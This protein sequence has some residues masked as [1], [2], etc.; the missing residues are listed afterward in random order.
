VAWTQVDDGTGSPALYRLKYAEP[1]IYWPGATVG[2]DRTLEGSAIGAGIS[3]TVEGLQPDTDY[4]LQ[5][6][7]F[8]YDANNVWAGVQVSNVTTGR[9]GA[10]PALSVQDLRI[11]GS[12]AQTLTVAWTQVDDGTGSPAWYRVKYAAPS[13]Q[14]SSATVGCDRTLVGT[15]IG[16]TISCTIEGLSVETEYDVQLVSYRTVDGVWVGGQRSNVTS[17]STIDA[18]VIRPVGDLTAAVGI[19]EMTLSWTQVND[20]QGGPASYQLRYAQP[21]FDWAA[22]DV[23]CDVAGTQIGDQATCTVTGLRAHNNE[24]VFQLVSFRDESGTW[25]D[26]LYS[27]PVTARTPRVRL[28]VND[29][30]VLSAT[31][32]TITLRWE[33]VSDALGYPAQYQVKY[34]SPL[35]SWGAATTGCD[36]VG[37]GVYVDISCTVTGLSPGTP[38]DFQLRSYRLEDGV[39]VGA[40]YS[41]ITSGSTAP[42]GG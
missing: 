39:W 15:Q 14:W 19:T 6:R 5:L 38:Y 24:Y 32:S 37:D 13:I 28:S 30:E 22:A 2:C 36:V 16:D 35:E 17:G 42:A 25:A 1:Q 33:Q 4:E 12:S 29:L 11:T 40:R 20:G 23:A 8:H 7:S 26:P 3:C 18:S 10:T 34:G 31:E 41:N 9:T 27:D 21:P